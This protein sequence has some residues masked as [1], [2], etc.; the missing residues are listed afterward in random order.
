VREYVYQCLSFHLT[1]TYSISENVSGVKD[2]GTS[3]NVVG[4][5]LGKNE[6]SGQ[7]VVGEVEAE[8]IFL[9]PTVR[10]ECVLCSSAFSVIKY[11]CS[12]SKCPV[13]DL[14]LKC[15]FSL[16][17]YSSS[18]SKCPVTDPRWQCLFYVIK[19][20]CSPIRC[21]ITDPM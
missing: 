2:E 16:I 7:N 11:S 21:L 4:D 18:P 17:K 6:Q 13:T 20:L 3:D 9:K 10:N 1:S 19:Y 15:L 8:P 14:K 12:P 5:K